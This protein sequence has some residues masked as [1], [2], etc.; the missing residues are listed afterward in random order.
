MT[1]LSEHR[2]RGWC[3]IIFVLAEPQDKRTYR[4]HDSWEGECQPE[5][6]V[7]FS[8]DH[9]DLTDDSPNVD[10]EVEVHIDPLCGGGRIHNDT[11]TAGERF[12]VWLL[13]CLLLGDKGRD[14]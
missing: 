13:D 10:H 12:G 1:E 7:S 8:V 6:D 2:A 14:V 4:K 3:V 5:P 9:G 11:L